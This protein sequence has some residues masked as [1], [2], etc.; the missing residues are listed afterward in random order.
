[1][2]VIGVFQEIRYRRRS[3]SH[4]LTLAHTVLGPGMRK[5]AG[6]SR[7]LRSEGIVASSVSLRARRQELSYQVQVKDS[8]ILDL[9]STTAEFDHQRSNSAVLQLVL[10]IVGP[11]LMISPYPAHSTTHLGQPFSRILDSSFLRLVVDID[12][13]ESRLEPSVPFKIIHERPPAG[14]ALVL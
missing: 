8:C 4:S 12:A 5:V 2:S 3:S 10:S 13:P 14:S 9:S 1:M 11:E 7:W 6:S